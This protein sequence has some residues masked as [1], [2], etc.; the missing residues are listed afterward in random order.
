MACGQ[1]RL[2]YIASKSAV[3]K[4]TVDGSMPVDATAR[5]RA[6]KRSI[7]VEVSPSMTSRTFG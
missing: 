6:S 3:V 7:E 1:L 5:N 4:R 2:V